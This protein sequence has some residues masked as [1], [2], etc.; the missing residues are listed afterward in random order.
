MQQI[1]SVH[2]SE[3]DLYNPSKQVA[4]HLIAHAIRNIP[5]N[6]VLLD[7]IKPA[8]PQNYLMGLKPHVYNDTGMLQ[9][10]FVN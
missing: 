8:K 10:G 5:N 2:N 4:D 1:Q 9:F 7:K 6:Q 3:V